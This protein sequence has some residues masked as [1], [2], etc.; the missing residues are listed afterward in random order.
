MSIVLNHIPEEFKLDEFIQQQNEKQKR[1]TVVHLSSDLDEFYSLCESVK[2][3]FKLDWDKSNASTDEL[4]LM[5]KK[6]II[7]YEQEEAMYKNKI[8]EYL[9]ANQ[10]TQE[11][12]P[13]W[14]TDLVSGIFH[15]NWGFAGIDQWLRDEDS[16]S[17]KLMG[18]RIY[19]L[20][21]GKQV[22]Q[23]QTMQPERIKQLITALMLN[24]P[25]KRMLDGYTELYMLNG[26]RITIFD[27]EIGKEPYIV[28]RKYTMKQYTFEEVARLETISSDSIPLWK[29]MINVGFNVSFTGAVRTSKT[30]FLITWQSLEDP[31]LE[32]IMVETDPEIP[33]HL[34]MPEAPI[35]QLVADDEK[36]KNIMK[37]LMRS[38]GDY[39]VMAEARDGIALKIAVQAAN[40]GTRRVKKTF[41]S[42]VPE[43]FCYDVAN[44]IVQEFGGD[45]FA[46]T[47]KVA[48]AFHY[49]FHFIQLKDKS[50]KRLKGVYEIRYNPMTLQV[51]MHQIVKYDVLSHAWTYKYDIGEDKR[52]IGLEEDYEAF[53]EF[54]RTLQELSEK[55]PMQGNHI[56]HLPY[57]ELLKK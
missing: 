53:Q 18:G 1:K 27:T 3:H 25:D 40:K 32:G 48:K 30:S 15:Q 47:I 51:S 50:K 41:H 44:E 55:Y 54:D 56:I 33:I 34:I 35:M 2:A 5:Q 39:I 12:F 46:N 4:L 26:N 45:V 21:N 23:K 6:A 13:D 42:G 43:D 36:L 9:K 14:Y 19:F 31:S 57:L 20:I 17:C 38:D 24:A 11:W 7:G 8:S 52:E 49:V 10:F 16:S 29:S 37:S 22:L 28:F